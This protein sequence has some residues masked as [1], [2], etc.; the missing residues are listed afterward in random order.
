MIR[1][2]NTRRQFEQSAEQFG[3]KVALEE[4]YYTEDPYATL[5]TLATDKDGN[6]LG[7]YW[8]LPDPSHPYGIYEGGVIATTEKEYLDEIHRPIDPENTP[9]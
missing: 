3:L 7:R 9:F 8:A 6:E 4:S 1:N 2:V 5:D